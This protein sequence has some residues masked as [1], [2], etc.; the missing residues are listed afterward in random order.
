MRRMWMRDPIKSQLHYIR[1]KRDEPKKRIWRDWEPIEKFNCFLMIFNA[2]LVLVGSIQAW[3][4]IESERATLLVDGFGFFRGITAD[5]PITVMFETINSGKSSGKID[6]I[7]I[8][9]SSS[10]PTPGDYLS[11]NMSLTVNPIPAGGSRLSFFSP[12]IYV[13]GILTPVKFT[14]NEI[15]AINANQRKFYI[16]GHMKYGDDY[17]VLLGDKAVE[18]CFVY[19]PDGSTDGRTRSDPCPFQ[20][21][22]QK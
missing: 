8:N 4:F 7:D 18:F 12:K 3:A 14:Q 5:T 6:N 10:L 15:D 9:Q 16:Y 20:H 11:S 21:P 17:S 19:D 2:L 13:N 1:D 22:R